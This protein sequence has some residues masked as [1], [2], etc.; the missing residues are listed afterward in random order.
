[1]RESFT[2][3]A[4]SVL[5][6]MSMLAFAGEAH[7]DEPPCTDAIRTALV[8]GKIRAAALDD[9]SVI[10]AEACKPWPY[11]PRL[12][13]ATVAYPTGVAEAASD[14]RTIT[15]I[16]AMIDADG[17]VV[18]RRSDEVGEDAVTEYS[19]GSLRLDTARYDL[20][21]GVRAFGVVFRSVARGASCPDR[22]FEDELTLY[23]RDGEQLRPV[24][25]TY[26]GV[27]SAVEGGLCATSARNVV[28][29]ADI[30]LS[31]GPKRSRG[32]ADIVSKAVVE[33]WSQRDTPEGRR[34]ATRTFRYDGKRYVSDAY[35]ASLYWEAELGEQ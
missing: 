4:A 10:V 30:T 16:T 33:R 7:A 26:L 18:A 22:S 8:S 34:H 1:V 9:S 29:H 35:E 20:A 21:P 32:Y 27:D 15:V 14:D 3:A 17:R 31:I 28:E 6:C 5:M 12:T 2:V 24:F 23:V 25:A 11:D 19:N 13:L